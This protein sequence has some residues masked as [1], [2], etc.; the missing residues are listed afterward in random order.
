MTEVANK[1]LTVK[2]LQLVVS[3]IVKGISVEDVQEIMDDLKVRW[4]FNSANWSP[5][6][7]IFKGSGVLNPALHPKVA[8]CI[9]ALDIWTV[10]WQPVAK[11][12]I[13]N[14]HKGKT[15]RSYKFTFLDDYEEMMFG[16]H[17]KFSR[18]R[19]AIFGSKGVL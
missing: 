6:T 8:A 15:L 1:P 4:P 19:K 3:V 5:K 12:I 14:F 7:A 9:M 13:V 11:E 16:K 10:T 2:D 18:L 17:D